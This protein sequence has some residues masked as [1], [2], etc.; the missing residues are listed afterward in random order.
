MFV[1]LFPLQSTIYTDDL[2][3]VVPAPELAQKVF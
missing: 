3:T 2:F 1:S